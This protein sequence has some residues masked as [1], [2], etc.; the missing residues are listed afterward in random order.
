[1]A[2]NRLSINES[3]EI[4]KKIPEKL[5]EKII[6]NANLPYLKKLKFFQKHFSE[7]FLEELAI[8]MEE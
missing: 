6:K 5:R 4:L 2:D 7:D 3:E 8:N 1:M